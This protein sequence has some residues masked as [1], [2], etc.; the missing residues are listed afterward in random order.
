[1][2][3]L[4]KAIIFIT[5][6]ASLFLSTNSLAQKV[7]NFIFIKINQKAITYSEVMDRT[8]L[9]LSLT[10]INR[11]TPE[12]KYLAFEQITQK[13]IEEE[14]IKQEAK[15]FSISASPA[16][17]EQGI[18]IFQIKQ[19]KTPKQFQNFLKKNNLSIQSLKNKI[20]AEIIW[21]KIINQILRPQITITEIEI[22]ELLEQQ[23]IDIK[24]KEYLLSQLVISGSKKSQQIIDKLYEE[25]ESGASFEDLVDQ[26]STSLS[27]ET[28]DSKIWLS[29]SDLNTNIYN[30]IKDLANSEY[31]KPIKIDDK[32]LIIKL[33]DSRVQKEISKNDRTIARQ[34]ILNKKLETKARGY[35]KRLKQQAFVE[36][37]K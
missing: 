25:L 12:D 18:E 37:Q 2:H 22:R 6:F 17:L 9:A 10:K 11:Q 4:C 3:Q 34:Y 1:M 31:S 21:G 15:K 7:Q 16:E 29:K 28:S 27:F 33:V 26:F 19:N 24:S 23:Q 32:Y 5:G 30:A 36:I 8:R 13:I 14:I 20:E 35:I